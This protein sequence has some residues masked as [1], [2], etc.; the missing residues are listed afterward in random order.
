[1]WNESLS[2]LDIPITFYIFSTDVK[3]TKTMVYKSEDMKSKHNTRKLD[4]QRQEAE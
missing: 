4:S 3:N 2:P 1:M